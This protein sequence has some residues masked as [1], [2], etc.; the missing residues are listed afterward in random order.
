MLE[1]SLAELQTQ[2]RL[3]GRADYA[4]AEL[5]RGYA[6]TGNREEAEKLLRELLALNP[7]NP[8]TA[9]GLAFLYGALGDN[10]QAFF[11]L[12]KSARE[13]WASS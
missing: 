9:I 12:E 5:A 11:W 10:E 1:E 13:R 6:L 3:S 2:A 4:L 8:G 7:Q